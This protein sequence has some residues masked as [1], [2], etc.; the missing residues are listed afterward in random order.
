M[1]NLLKIKKSYGK[2][3]DMKLFEKPEVHITPFKLPQFF[4]VPSEIQSIW[5]RIPL[6]TEQLTPVYGNHGLPPGMENNGWMVAENI[7]SRF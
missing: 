7:D 1:H 2:K 4:F 6:A 5:F 3:E